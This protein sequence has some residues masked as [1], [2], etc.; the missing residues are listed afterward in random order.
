MTDK[1]ILSMGWQDYTGWRL[2]MKTI[3]AGMVLR[4]RVF[5]QP[6]GTKARFFFQWAPNREPITKPA[7]TSITGGEEAA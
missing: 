4:P 3:L 5:I 1:W 6:P 7:P 2:E